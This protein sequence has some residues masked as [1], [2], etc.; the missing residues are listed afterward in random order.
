[1]SLALHLFGF[2]VLAVVVYGLYAFLSTK[3]L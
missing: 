3:T 1:M 2:A